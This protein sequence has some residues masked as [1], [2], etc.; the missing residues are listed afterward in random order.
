MKSESPHLTRRQ[1]ISKTVAA[2]AA[3]SG[4]RALLAQSQKW[5]PS[6]EMGRKGK[7]YPDERRKFTDP[8]SGHTIWQLTNAKRFTVKLY[9]TNRAVTPDSRWMIYLSDR[10]STHER[11][12]LFKMDL[13]TG[14]SIQLTESGAVM[15]D[16]PEISR[17][18]R[19]VYYT[20]NNA[21]RTID[22]ESLKERQVCLFD[23]PIRLTHALTV[24]SDGR[25]VITAAHM[26]PLKGKLGY[27]FGHRVTRDGLLMI[28]T[29]TGET[30]PLINGNTPLGHVA[31]SPT[32]PNLVLYS[33]H[34]HWA[35]IQRPWLIN[36]DGTGNRIIFRQ[37]QGEGIGHE[38]WG[39]SG[40]TVYVSCY[41]GRQPE[42]L[43]ACN[44]DGSNERCVLA[45]PNIAHGCANPQEDRF[46]VDE[47]L[48]DTSSLWYSKK[49]SSEPIFLHKMA[50]DWFAVR[51]GVF[52][53]TDFHPHPRFLEDGTGVLFNSGGEIYLAQ[54]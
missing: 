28:K 44:V 1:F 46:V 50:A 35:E 17:N 40:N 30:R 37:S 25:H 11:L 10:G 16:T 33:L 34:V 48:T 32:N 21:V 23:P 15:E 6:K 36:A 26:E 9:Y 41:A 7:V 18:G 39:A 53:A 4:G 27:N 2:G 3:L 20:E 13:K 52:Q 24:S 49:G 8:K 22:M 43:W 29:E 45:G 31:F 54:F 51:D 42:G 19:E 12:N 5:E 14:E 38:W 47:L